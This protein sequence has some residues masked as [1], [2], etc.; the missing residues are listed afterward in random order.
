M[1]PRDLYDLVYVLEH[2]EPVGQS[3]RCFDL[4][5][6]VDGLTYETAGAFLLGWDI[7]ANASAKALVL[8]EA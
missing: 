7:R 1:F 3:S 4:A 8:T 6:D 2:Y 5:G